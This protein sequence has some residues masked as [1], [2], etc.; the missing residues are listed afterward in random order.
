MSTLNLFNTIGLF[1]DLIGVILIFIYSISPM[2]DE[3]GT[4]Y[5]VG[6]QNNNIEKKKVKTYKCLSRIGLI[7]IL[8]GF[9][10]QLISN[11]YL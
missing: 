11:F 7:L 2:L 6:E 9:M 1:L 4:T 10:F 3:N 8:I 5:M